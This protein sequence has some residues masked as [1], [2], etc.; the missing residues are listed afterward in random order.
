MRK[1]SS[2]EAWRLL[3]VAVYWLGLFLVA[4]V[5]FAVPVVSIALIL[6]PGSVV[7]GVVGLALGFLFALSML[8][9]G[10]KSL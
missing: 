7:G 2:R 5:L 4:F 6:F 10:W 1:L 9:W 8:R 3:F